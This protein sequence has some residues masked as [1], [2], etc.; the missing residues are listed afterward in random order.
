MIAT[1]NASPKQRRQSRHRNDNRPMG[2]TPNILSV[3]RYKRLK[4]AVANGTLPKSVLNVTM[5]IFG[6]RKK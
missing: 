1:R 6:K 3:W 2:Y 5:Q 4:A